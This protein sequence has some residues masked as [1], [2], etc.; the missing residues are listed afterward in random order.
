MKKLIIAALL[1]AAGLGSPVFVA[2]Q[3]DELAQLALNI[4]KLAQFRTILNDMKRGYQLLEGGYNTVKGIA[5]GNFSLH[6]TF[7]DGLLAVSPAVRKYR[8]IAD[9]MEGQLQLVNEYKT[10]YRRFS[11]YDLFNSSELAYLGRVYGRVFDE[12]LQDLDALLTIVTSGKAR[13]SDAERLEAIDQIHLRM[14][15]KLQFV[16]NF[17]NNTTV[18]AVQRAKEQHDVQAIRKLY[19]I[20]K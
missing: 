17:N 12:S 10:A 5:A 2:A 20:I 11:G 8:R 3:A 7:L 6:K 16:R 9:I 19:G 4:E 18:L 15:D 1:F 14:Q 13:M